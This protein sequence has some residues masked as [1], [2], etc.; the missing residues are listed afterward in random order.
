MNTKFEKMFDAMLDMPRM[1]STM[2]QLVEVKTT[3][4]A[5]IAAYT[6]NDP[7]A[8]ADAKER[9]AELSEGIAEGEQVIA[10]AEAEVA[11]FTTVA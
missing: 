6:G 10:K 9:L 1:K 4:E 7:Q 3:L 8:L 2:A 11:K 5:N